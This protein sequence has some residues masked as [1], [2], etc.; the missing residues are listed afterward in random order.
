M[1][2]APYSDDADLSSEK[3]R[4][5][6]DGSLPFN[7]ISIVDVNEEESVMR[8]HEWGRTTSAD[9]DT[10][11]RSI[12]GYQKR[13]ASLEEKLET[14]VNSYADRVTSL[15]AENATLSDKVRL[16]ETEMRSMNAIKEELKAAK[17]FGYVSYYEALQ[18][19][20][21]ISLEQQ[22]ILKSKA[23]RLEAAFVSQTDVLKECQTEL[24]KYKA[25]AK[26]SQKELQDEMLFMSQRYD[27]LEMEYTKVKATS[28]ELRRKLTEKEHYGELQLS[29]R[30]AAENAKKIADKRADQC[31]TELEQVA[32]TAAKETERFKRELEACYKV[33][34]RGARK[35]NFRMILLIFIPLLILVGF[36][37]HFITICLC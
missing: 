11:K 3:L 14:T 19:E 6:S 22:G 27:D 31:S 29:H 25:L 15:E 23:G 13:C 32:A 33:S 7:E 24:K 28:E 17:K 12:L 18:S 26:E 1:E 5:H 30:R 4:R 21:D 20:L 8:I 10:A 35:R 2:G 36:Y 37:S 9:Y 34:Q 16:L